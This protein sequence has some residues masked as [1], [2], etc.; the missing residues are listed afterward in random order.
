MVARWSGFMGLGKKGE[1]MNE[2]EL[3]Q[4]CQ[5]DVKY[6]IDIIGNNIVTTMYGAMWVL[7]Y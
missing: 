4:N 7:G 3:L 2:Y 6:S 5:G 1:R